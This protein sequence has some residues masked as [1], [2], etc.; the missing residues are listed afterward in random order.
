MKTIW[1]WLGDPYLHLLAVV[2][3]VVAVGVA[4][5]SRAEPAD[6]CEF[7]QGAHDEANPCAAVVATGPAASAPR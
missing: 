4:G 6:R 2:T 5:S 3:V 1:S 7:C